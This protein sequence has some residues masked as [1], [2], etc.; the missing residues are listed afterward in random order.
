MKRITKKSGYLIITI[1][2]MQKHPSFSNWIRFYDKERINLLMEKVKILDIRYYIYLINSKVNNY[3]LFI[4][5][6][7]ITASQAESIGAITA[8]VCILAQ[9]DK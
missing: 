8:V 2:Y 3:K 5:T 4:E 1:P 6:N 7:E 9:N